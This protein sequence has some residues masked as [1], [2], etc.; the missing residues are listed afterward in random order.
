MIRTYG[1]VDNLRSQMMRNKSLYMPTWRQ[2]AE[3]ISPHYFREFSERNNG[4]RKDEKILATQARRGLRTFVS[5]MSNG[6]TPQDEDWFKIATADPALNAMHDSKKYFTQLELILNHYFQLSNTYQVLPMAYK[7]MGI[8][9]NSAFAMLPHAIKGFYFYPFVVGSYSLSR[10][11]DGDVNMFYRDFTMTVR[12]TVERFGKKKENGHI[13]WTNMDPY[14]KTLWEASRYA[15]SVMLTTVILPNDNPIRHSFSPLEKAFQAYTYMMAGGT[16][17][18][19]P[20]QHNRGFRTMNQATAGTLHAGQQDHFISVKGYDY[21]PVIAA[22]WE[23][24]PEDD[25]GVDGPGEIALGDI[26]ELQEMK[27]GRAKAVDLMLR[28]PMV[29]P[30][31]LRR[32]QSSILAGGITYV[33][34]NSETAK[35]RR[36]FEVD[37]KVSDLVNMFEEAKRDIDEAFYVDVFRKLQGEELKSHVAARAI[38]ELAQEKLNTINPMLGQLDRDQNGPM[39]RNGLKIL[40]AQGLLPETPKELENQKLKPEYISPLAKASK[41]GKV[42][43]NEETMNFVATVAGAWQDPAYLKMVNAENMIREFAEWKG[44]SPANITSTREFAKFQEAAAQ[45]RQ[46]VENA[47]IAKTTSETARNLGQTQLEQPDGGKNM[48]SLAQE[49]V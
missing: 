28:P 40:G 2:L 12:Q 41:A 33:D 34:E 30:P 39:I 1:E 25:W 18:G 19:I 16:G 15:D 22:G 17:A 47:E 27:Y 45:R 43:A 32:H 4:R 3:F 23:I 44:V 11:S 9:S 46:Q 24:P 42:K 48:L 37:P 21:F 6:N 38:D 36:A 31:S 5:G 14:V 20:S 13:D 7:S 49:E 35:Y 10:N 26:Q 8:F 29:G